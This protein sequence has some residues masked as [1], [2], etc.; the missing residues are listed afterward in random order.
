MRVRPGMG[1]C[2]GGYCEIEIAKI[3]AR[4]LHIPLQDVAYNETTYY[5]LSKE[6]EQ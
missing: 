4:E 2:Q 1:K 6:D 5:S 3:L